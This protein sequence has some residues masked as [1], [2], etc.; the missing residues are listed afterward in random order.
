VVQAEA[1]GLVVRFGLFAS[2][3][4]NILEV[5]AADICPFADMFEFSRDAPFW[6]STWEE[7]VGIVSLLGQTAYAS[8]G[9]L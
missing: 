4:N 8:V 6:L 7:K 1:R 2:A 3:T 5:Q 9:Y